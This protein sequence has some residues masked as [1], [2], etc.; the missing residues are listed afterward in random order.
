MI[1]IIVVEDSEVVRTGIIGLLN[2]EQ[3]MEV[4][5]FAENG[6]QAIEVLEQGIE[7]DIVLADLNMPKMD[8]IVLTEHIVSA[9]PTVAVVIFTMHVRSEFVDKALKAGAR[10]YLLK[11]GDF[12]HIMEGIRK[13]SQGEIFVSKNVTVSTN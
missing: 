3:D 1:R 9:F 2:Y 7:A 8:G 4:V 11:D 5:A 6:L 12:E 10:G 13:V